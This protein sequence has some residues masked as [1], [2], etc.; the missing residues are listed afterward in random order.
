M[1][2]VIANKSYLLVAIVLLAFFLRFWQLGQN[3]PGLYVD[4]VSLGYNA[5]SILKTAHDEYGNFM[6]LVFRSLNT[7]NPALSVYTLVPS[8]AAFQLNEFAVR[9]PSALAGTLTVLLTYFL[10]Y[11]LFKKRNIAQVASLLLAISP[12]HLQFSRFY[13]EANIMVFFSILGLVLL[14]YSFKKHYLVYLSA[15]S[16]G[17]AANTFHGAKLWI[18]LF[19]FVI[20]IFYNREIFKFGKKLIIALLILAVFSLPTILNFQNSL[21]RPNSVS[22]FKEKKPQETFISGYLSHFSPNFLFMQGDF[23]G[24]HEVPGMGELYIFELP[25]ILIGLFNLVRQKNR[26]AKFLL[27]WFLIAPIPAALAAPT[28][29]AGRALVFLPLWQIIAAFGAYSLWQIK[30]AKYTKSIALVL[31]ALVAIY[32][33]ATYFH[34]YYKHY[35][36]EKAPDWSDGHKQMVQYI[37]QVYNGY[38]S[39]AITKYYGYPYIYLLFYLK[40]DPVKY[41]P[42]SENKDAFDKFH[43]YSGVLPRTFGKTLVITTPQPNAQNVIKQIKMNNGDTVF[44]AQN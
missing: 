4:E 12:W 29:H 27:A 20:L 7:Y 26:T 28:P 23:M 24:R 38:D 9:F 17:I 44:V 25:L 36:K 43:F 16:F 31:L 5:Y 41:Q 30:I 35:S 6:P 40:Y 10:T 42:Q 22:I 2:T 3:P 15:I 34:L 19:L 13:H 32:N 14:F 8:I 33:I 39:I 21:V 11:H 37:G 18:P 1:K